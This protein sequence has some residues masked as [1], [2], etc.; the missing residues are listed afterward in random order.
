MVLPP[1]TIICP[2]NVL[3][4]MHKFFVPVLRSSRYCYFCFISVIY[5]DS[6]LTRAAKHGRILVLDEAD[7]AP[8]DVVAVL[9][10][11]IEDGQLALPDGA[12]VYY[13]IFD[14]S[15]SSYLLILSFILE[16]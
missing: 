15:A 16:F 4:E 11:L 9:K 1:R 3:M 14:T 12:F 2:L 5:H 6:P 10:G 7:K 8:V 13:E